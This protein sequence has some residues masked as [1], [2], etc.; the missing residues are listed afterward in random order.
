MRP[1]H[2]DSKTLRHGRTV[3]MALCTTLSLVACSWDDVEELPSDSGPVVA[4]VSIDPAVLQLGGAG[5]S[6]LLIATAHDRLEGFLADRS[7][8]WSVSDASVATID[9]MG[10]VKALAVGSTSVT[11]TTDGVEGMASVQVDPAFAT[12]RACG[13]C[14]GWLR[15]DHTDLGFS[16]VSCWVCHNPAGETHRQ[17]V[18]NHAAAA[19]GYE[20]LD[21][22]AQL[23][24][25]GCH[26]KSADRLRFSPK[27]ANDC[28]AC[29]QSDY[30]VQHAGTGYP[31]TCT[32]CHSTS[33]WSGA[34]F[35]HGV[36]SGGFDL[37]GRHTT[38]PC[39][40]CHDAVT[41]QPLFTPADETDCAACHQS[42]YDQQHLGS[43]Y[44][45]SCLTCHDGSTWTGG[46]FD[47]DA[48]Y[49]PIYSGDHAGEW[50]SCGICHTQSGDFSVFTCF[51]CHRHNQND[52]DDTH[53]GMTG[54]AY[55]PPT[56]LG[57]HPDGTK[58]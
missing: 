43:G 53:S 19:G 13:Q 49:F 36:A 28:I 16:A 3:K 10:L 27:D 9:S 39:T 42:D 12:E 56:C 21:V 58:P 40:S 38:L 18:N 52:M 31:T 5:D 47:H 1:G 48:D 8:S 14:H 51:N 34:T 23:E 26:V 54:Y 17:F 55:D 7:F 15:G 46:R 22:H 4:A 37:T 32:S 57:C 35:D 50:Q 20:L 33:A 41:G 6:A 44:P 25:G 24:C 45:T 29:H 2:D 30:D 11:A